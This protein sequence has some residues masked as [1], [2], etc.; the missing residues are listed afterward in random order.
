MVDMY[1]AGIYQ[2]F[3]K[4]LPRRRV[5]ARNINEMERRLL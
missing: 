5:L 3:Q 1:A 4:T 2:P